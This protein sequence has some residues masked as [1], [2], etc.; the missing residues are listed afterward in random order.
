MAYYLGRDVL[1][2]ITTELAGFGIDVDNT[3][4]K[5]TFTPGNGPSAGTDTVFAGP[6]A[7]NN[8]V[9]TPFTGQTVNT[10]VFGTQDGA[11]DFSNEVSDLTAC[12]VTI[13]TVDE[14]VTYIGQKSTLKA[15]IKKE[16]SVSLTR[17]KKDASWDVVFNTA[18]Y[19]ISAEDAYYGTDGPENPAVSTFGYRVYVLLKSSIT[20]ET[21]VLPNCQITAHSV[22]I[23]ADGATEETL[24]LQTFISPVVTTIAGTDLTTATSDL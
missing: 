24:E 4:A 9:N 23:N 20:G 2:A 1:V 6:L 5:D 21:L 12:D 17:K 18:R 7:E 14:D 13:G 10:T 8:L 3:G 15:E 16:T 19:G 11:I 22:S